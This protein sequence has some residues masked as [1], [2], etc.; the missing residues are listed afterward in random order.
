MA[1]D[2]KP[3]E[4]LSDEAKEAHLAALEREAE[5]LDVSSKHASATDDQRE[6]RARRAGEARAEIKRIGGKA[7]RL[8][9]E[10]V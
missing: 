5:Y 4:F 7:T 9:G 2:D 8:R 10:A 1:D 6:S 3:A